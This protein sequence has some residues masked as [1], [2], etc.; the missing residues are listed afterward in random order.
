MSLTSLALVGGFFTT[1]TTWEAHTII[2]SILL[3]EQP[4]RA[5]VK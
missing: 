1:S 4:M 2:I 5:K 3:L